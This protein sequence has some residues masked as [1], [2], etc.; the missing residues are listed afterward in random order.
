[1]KLYQIWT[2]YGSEGWGKEEA[3]TF[4]DAIVTREEQLSM[5]N[6]EVIITKRVDFE[7][8][9][10]ELKVANCYIPKVVDEVREIGDD[11]AA[12]SASSVA[13]TAAREEKEARSQK[14]GDHWAK[15]I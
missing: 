5:G 8:K 2:N 10:T 15:G 7:V 14:V 6:S 1:M 9:E 4:E 12:A 11:P 3:E 13:W